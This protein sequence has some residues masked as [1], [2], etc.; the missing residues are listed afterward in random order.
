[1]VDLAEGEVFQGELARYNPTPTLPKIGGPPEVSFKVEKINPIV[2]GNT[3]TGLKV[4]VVDAKGV[5]RELNINSPY[6]VGNTSFV[7]KDL[8]VA[9]LFVIR[10]PAGRE[11]DRAYVKLNVM[12]G[13]GDSFIMGG[14][15]FR[16]HFYPD[17]TVKDGVAA[18][19]TDEFRNPVFSLIVERQGKQITQG[20][21]PRNGTLSFDGYQLE[22]QQMPFWVRFMVIKEYGLSILYAGFA[23]ACL[24]V[25]WRFLFFRREIIGAVREEGG[26][27]RLVVAG[28]SE[29]YKALAVDEFTALFDDALVAIGGKSSEHRM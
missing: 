21:I 6:D 25:I 17:Y 23:L 29:F 10:D 8:G 27:Q 19:R 22:M 28:R 24:A 18:T 14:F 3:P 4:Q 16:A 12:K 20:I 11:I 7:I 2:S 26:G 5:V 13:R 9:P 1:V 15:L